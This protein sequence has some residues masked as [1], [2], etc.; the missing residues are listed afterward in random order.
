MKNI[1]ILGA[2]GSIGTQ[3]LD[4]LRFHKG[5]FNLVGIS[6]YKNIDLVLDIIKEFKP[7]VIAINNKEAFDKLKSLESTLDGEFE[8]SMVWTVL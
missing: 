8:Y 1:S 2:T 3:T 5:E 6:A 7:K 4:V